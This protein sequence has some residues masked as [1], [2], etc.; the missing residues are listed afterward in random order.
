MEYIKIRLSIDP[1]FVTSLNKDWYNFESLTFHEHKYRYRDWLCKLVVK[2]GRQRQFRRSQKTGGSIPD[3]LFI[4]PRCAHT[5]FRVRTRI[6]NGDGCTRM[7]TGRA[8][9]E[10]NLDIGPRDYPRWI[11]RAIDGSSIDTWRQRAKDAATRLRTC[12]SNAC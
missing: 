9:P 4:D 5:R 1:N 6:D 2:P 8:C 12:S 3:L 11:V 10:I 7:L